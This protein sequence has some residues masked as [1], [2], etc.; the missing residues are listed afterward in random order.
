MLG[1]AG[2]ESDLARKSNDTSE[3]EDE[4]GSM[5]AEEA[6]ERMNSRQKADEYE[7]PEM[8]EEEQ[9]RLL[10]SDGM[11][12]KRPLL[13]TEDTVLPGFKEAQWAEMI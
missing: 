13:V 3:D 11:L 10:A 4:N 8:T 1:E 12:V 9:L 7:K 2:T 6:M 5:L